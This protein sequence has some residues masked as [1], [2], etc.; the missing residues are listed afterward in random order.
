MF[1]MYAY[2]ESGT[3]KFRCWH[4]TFPIHIWEAGPSIPDLPSTW[5]FACIHESTTSLI[6][7]VLE[8]PKINIFNIWL[9]H[10]Q[11]KANHLHLCRSP[12]I[13]PKTINSTLVHSM[14]LNHACF[15]LVYSPL[16]SKKV[17]IYQ[18]SKIIP[19]YN[20]VGFTMMLMLE[21]NYIMIA[22]CR[23]QANYHFGK[24]FI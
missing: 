7:R 2:N 10:K 18:P 6:L 20:S 19:W 5:L 1:D 3:P 11:Y 12:T 16:L 21:L 17:T 9:L 15:T 23:D 14:F 4:D 13:F 24:C 8:K 22:D